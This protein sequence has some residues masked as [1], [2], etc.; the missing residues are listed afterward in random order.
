[1]KL[2]KTLALALAA[3]S[4][5]S[6]SACS[7]KND[8][9]AGTNNGTSANNGT[10]APSN[11]QQEDVTITEGLKL[12]VLTNR[13]D[14]VADG[15]FAEM[16]KPFEEKYKCTVEFEEHKD[17]EGDVANMMSTSD[18]GDVLLIPNNVKVNDLP[19][20]F[21]PLGS[22]DDLSKTYKWADQKSNNGT[23]Y[24]IAHI[25]TVSGGIVYNKKI[26]ADAG[27]TEMPKTPE[28]FIND[29]KKIKEKFPDVIPYYTNY[30]AGW[31]MN[32]WSDLPQAISGD[33]DMKNSMMK[34]KEPLC[35]EGNTYYQVY[36]LIY[37]LFSEA[38]LIEE[39]HANTNWDQSK[40]DLPA[41]KIATM[42][43]GSW[44][45]GQIKGEA[46]NNGY[47]PD[48]VGY[49]PAPFTGADGKQSAI[50]G[51]D[52]FLAVNKN[53]SDDVKA[54]AKAYVFWFVDESGFC[55]HESGVPV[56]VDGKFP[57][58]LSA[59]ADCKM[60]Q[61]NPAAEGLEG[62]WDNIDK[63]S[64]VGIYSDAADNF[65]MKLAEAAFQGKGEEGFKEVIDDVNE[66][67]SAALDKESALN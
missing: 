15:Y 20:F 19:D 34:N 58:T 12:R 14:R 17:Y 47:N 5:L 1:M 39:G 18:Y 25:G 64:D 66:K 57:D 55:D 52:Y 61:E 54:L 48:D 30:A 21:E 4:V 41:G 32:Q 23:V 56:Q 6:M 65:K 26:W 24:G 7:Q 45:V 63:E 31:T 40:I 50:S 11:I 22:Y 2:K 8:D 60:F 29:L 28:E 46:V 42:V 36:K 43:L 27:I 33:P 16:V 62:V 9:P 49:M 10:N 38:D 35:K 59:F 67:W 3:A 53:S 37:D 44:A 51:P 13:D